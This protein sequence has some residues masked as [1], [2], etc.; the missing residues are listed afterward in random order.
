M[1]NIANH[2]SNSLFLAFIAGIPLYG[3]IKKLM[4][5]MRLQQVPNKDLK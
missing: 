5:L 1:S 3:A 4:F 2:I